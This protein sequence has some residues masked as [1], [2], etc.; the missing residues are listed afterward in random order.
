[1]KDG[2]SKVDIIENNNRQLILSD[3]VIRNL[4]GTAEFN[5]SVT[6]GKFLKVVQALIEDDEPASVVSKR[7][8][9]DMR[10]VEKIKKYIDK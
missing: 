8:T 6:V 2:A 4:L 10:M 3:S 1:M 7:F 5:K 9:I